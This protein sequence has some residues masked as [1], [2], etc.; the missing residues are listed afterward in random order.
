[1]SENEFI[2]ATEDMEIL[3][4]CVKEYGTLNQ[5]D[6]A[7]EEMSELIKALIK[8]RRYN[9]DDKRLLNIAEEMADVYIMLLQLGIIFDNQDKVKYFF[10]MK[11][12]RE[13]DRL[14]ERFGE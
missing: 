14:K 1:M 8:Q 3:R 12:N 10:K 2:L 4:D 5:V 7:I 6:I 13:K 11:I 9:D